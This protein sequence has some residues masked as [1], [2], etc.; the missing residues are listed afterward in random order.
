VSSRNEAALQE[1]KFEPERK[2]RRSGVFRSLHVFKVSRLPGAVEGWALRAVDAEA[3]EPAF[4]RGCG[5]AEV[6]VD[7]IAR[8]ILQLEYRA[9]GRP[10]LFGTT[11]PLALQDYLLTEVVPPR[12]CDSSLTR[13]G[14]GSLEVDLSHNFEAR[15]HVPE[16]DVHVPGDV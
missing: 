3:G 14:I 8:Q 16:A 2:S 5:R 12:I 4:A 15:L 13:L 9:Q 7:G 10:S 6:E 1:R 11:L